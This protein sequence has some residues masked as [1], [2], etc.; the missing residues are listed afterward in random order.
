MSE[1]ARR[2]VGLLVQTSLEGRDPAKVSEDLSELAPAG[3][4]L[5]RKDIER[6]GSA[7]KSVR[8]VRRALKDALASTRVPLPLISADEEGGYVRRV[9]SDRTPSAMALG[10]S[11]DYALTRKASLIIGQKLHALGINW[12]FA[13]V[14]DVNFEPS[15]PV[16][17]TRS[18]G[19]NPAS[20]ASHVVAF[21]QG[22]KAAGVLSCAKHF[23]GHG[24]SSKDSHLELPTIDADL[25]TILTSDLVPFR[26]AIQ[27]NVDA[28]MVGH[29]YYPR[30]QKLEEPCSVSREIISGLLRQGLGFDGVVATDALSMRG[31]RE[32]MEVG[33]A[34]VRAIKAGCDLVE[35]TSLDMAWAARHSLEES[36]SAGELETGR[37]LESAARVKQLMQ[38]GMAMKKSVLG[39]GTPK[40]KL[41]TARDY[42]RCVTLYNQG[43]AF[44]RRR[45]LA[46]V[47][48]GSSL[49]PASDKLENP[50]SL[51]LKRLGY[52]V[53]SSLRLEDSPR[54]GERY[55]ISSADSSKKQSVTGVLI[56][57]RDSHMHPQWAEQISDIAGSGLPAGII[58]I[59][60]P[61]ESTVL[62][63]GVRYV[64]TYS[65]LE[66]SLCAALRTLTSP[67]ARTKPGPVKLLA[68]KVKKQ[69]NPRAHTK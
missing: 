62:P 38:K 30:I 13:P 36:L 11:S 43:A 4:V 22:L 69:R 8:E 16:I 33:E 14:A 27:S 53:K 9:E 45:E 24:R 5:F 7:K 18:F 2:S 42:T 48:G 68:R 19:D 34:A 52:Y 20:V 37:V 21:I 35:T 40:P 67:S 46:V 31:L 32:R 17:A 12:D 28:V 49:S 56:V 66:E 10:A 61:Y 59:G 47:V 15:N 39:A 6:A 64:C 26:A 25:E 44:P 58:G 55:R 23:P 1:V 57:L 63:G 60:T 29:L 3:V 54:R 50:L 41:F 51:A 65:S